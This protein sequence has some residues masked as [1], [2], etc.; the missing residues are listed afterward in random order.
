MEEI[1][2]NDTNNSVYR[3]IVLGEENSLKST[4]LNSLS[5]NRNLFPINGEKITKENV[6]GKKFYSKKISIDNK[7]FELNDTI[8]IN[9]TFPV[10][11]LK[12][13]LIKFKTNVLNQKFNVVLTTFPIYK[14]VASSMSTLEKILQTFSFSNN[15]NVYI[16]F[17]KGDMFETAMQREEEYTN[18]QDDIKRLIKEKQ[19]QFNYKNILMYDE[20]TKESFKNK[21]MLLATDM[22]KE[23]TY[24]MINDQIDYDDNMLMKLFGTNDTEGKE[25]ISS[26]SGINVFFNWIKEYLNS[27]AF[28]NNPNMLL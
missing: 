28:Y 6:S 8:G 11:E 14:K 2:I 3:V 19:Y 25:G 26:S 27:H 1:N 15:Q 13:K 5:D 17:T 21:I 23:A 12:S 10:S 9:T 18:V 4:I 7:I 24:V 16:V 20:D 22:N